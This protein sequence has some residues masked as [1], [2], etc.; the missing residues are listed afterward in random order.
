MRSSRDTSILIVDDDDT[1]R[2]VTRNILVAAGFKVA[3][4]RDFYEAIDLVEKDGKIDIA[5]VDVVMPRGTP[6]G[7]SFARMAK[8]RR[9]SLKVIFMSA[10]VDP[11]GLALYDKNEAFLSKPFAP[12][13]LLDAIARS[14]A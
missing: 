5:I 3:C 9:P 11:T 13:N 2:D 1:C 14:A 6:H 10:R 7:L 4:A 8:R 12:R